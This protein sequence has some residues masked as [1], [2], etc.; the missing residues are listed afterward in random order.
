VGFIRLIY[1][2]IYLFTYLLTYLRRRTLVVMTRS[3]TGT[4]LL[5]MSHLNY[6]YLKYYAVDSQTQPLSQLRLFP[7][8]HLSFP[9][10]FLL[11]RIF[12]PDF[13][14]ILRVYMYNYFQEG[15]GGLVLQQPPSL[16]FSNH[17]LFI[18]KLRSILFGMCM[19]ST[20]QY[21]TVQ[22]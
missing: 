8:F 11:I 5:H 16:I 20:V 7:F 19:Y 1:L 18:I 2:Y 4:K 14:N 12:G 15:A 10:S 17:F 21:S 22:W 6:N 13:L 9:N 3:D